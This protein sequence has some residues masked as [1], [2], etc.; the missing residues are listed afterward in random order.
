MKKLFLLLATVAV[1]VTGCFEYRAYVKY[2]TKHGDEFMCKT[3]GEDK[4]A[5][6]TCK[7]T[8][9]RGGVLY[10]CEVALDKLQKGYRPDVAVDCQ[11]VAGQDK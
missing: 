4:V 1:L 2:Q 7:F 9:N 3:E 10:A 8:I 6:L 11:L 5:D